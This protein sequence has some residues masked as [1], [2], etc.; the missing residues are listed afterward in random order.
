M[1]GR[2]IYACCGR[3]Q[4]S[5][6]G[7][8]G[9]HSSGASVCR[10]M[11]MCCAYHVHMCCVIICMYAQHDQEM[12]AHVLHMPMCFIMLSFCSTCITHIHTSTILPTMYS[13]QTLPT[14][15]PCFAHFA[16]HPLFAHFIPSIT[17]AAYVFS[18]IFWVQLFIVEQQLPVLLDQLTAH[19]RTTVCER[20]NVW[21]E[22]KGGGGMCRWRW[23]AWKVEKE[24]RKPPDTHTDTR[25]QP[26]P[27]HLLVAWC[28]VLQCWKNLA[29]PVDVCPLSKPTALAHLTVQSI[30]I[31]WG[32]VAHVDLVLQVSC[33]HPSLVHLGECSEV[34]QPFFSR[35]LTKGLTLAHIVVETW[36]VGGVFC[37]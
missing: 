10:C 7:L 16:T 27:K 9:D 23:Y 21:R 37:V 6:Q 29:R 34:G 20:D 33:Q 1:L 17:H 4:R 2:R 36:V 28:V 3:N 5:G 31:Q 18:H 15:Y 8:V 26:L 24:K 14:T 35:A 22:E 30:H 11:Y 25:T 12:Y 32:P 19:T 13:P